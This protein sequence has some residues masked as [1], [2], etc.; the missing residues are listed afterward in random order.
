MLINGI[1][2]TKEDFEKLLRDVKQ[3]K[4]DLSEGNIEKAEWMLTVYESHLEN[5]LLTERTKEGKIA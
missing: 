5:N 4:L 3:M 1:E 2:V